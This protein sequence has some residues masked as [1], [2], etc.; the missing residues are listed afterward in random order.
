VI[1]AIVREGSVIYQQGIRTGDYLIEVNGIPIND[2]C[3]Y[4]LIENRRNGTRLK[5]RSPDGTVKQA[6]WRE[7]SNPSD[8]P[9]D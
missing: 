5:F 7:L 1:K 8:S 3:T 2:I 6:T 9:R 4:M